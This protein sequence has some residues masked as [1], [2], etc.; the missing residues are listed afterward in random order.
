[1]EAVEGRPLR[2]AVIVNMVAPY[3]KPL[4]EEL[5]RRSECELLV[6]SETTMERDRKWAPERELPFDNVLLESWTFDLAWL[7]LRLLVQ[8]D[9]ETPVRHLD[10]VGAVELAQGVDP[11]AGLGQD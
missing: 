9:T 8:E 7:A 1:M 5:A 6:V 10:A 3:T 4:F 11:R 2:L